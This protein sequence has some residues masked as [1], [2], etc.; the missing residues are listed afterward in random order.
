LRAL[1]PDAARITDKM[2]AN[3]HHVGLI[4]L[5]LPN[6]RIIHTRRNPLDT[7]LSCFAQNFTKGQPFTNDL[8][9]LGRYYKAYARLM[10]HWREVLPEPFMLEVDYEELVADFEPQLRRILAYCGL[11]WDPACLSFH[12]NPRAVITASLLQVRQPLYQH[13]ANRAG[14]YGA[15]LQP[16]RDALEDSEY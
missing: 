6:A 13:A 7:C 3:F 4:R 15:M 1:A 14:H 5:M 10:S 8:G 9:E 12:E 2:P 16:L 11:A